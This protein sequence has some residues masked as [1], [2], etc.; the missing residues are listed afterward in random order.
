MDNAGINRRAGSRIVHGMDPYNLTGDF[1][2]CA[3]SFFRLET[4]VCGAASGFNGEH[5][6]SLSRG[7][8]AT[9]RSRWL[10]YENGARAFGFCLDQTA[11]GR[12]SVLLI[13]SEKQNN[14]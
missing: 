4:G 9:A 13:A 14:R 2:N 1:Q 5:P 7:F 10:E 11:A 6:S 3:R 8:D 12:A